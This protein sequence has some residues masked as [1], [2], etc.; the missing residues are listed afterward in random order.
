LDLEDLELSGGDFC[1]DSNKELYGNWT[2]RIRSSREEISLLL[3][4][5]GRR[6]DPEVS[7]AISVWILIRKCEEN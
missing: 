7:G 2:W 3:P 1:I 6:E 4:G 5:N